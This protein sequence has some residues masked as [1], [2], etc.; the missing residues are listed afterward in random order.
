MRTI[1]HSEVVQAH[2]DD[3]W[4]VLFNRF[5]HVNDWNPNIEHSSNLTERD[6]EIG[7]E[8]MCQIDKDHFVREKITKREG[9]EAME[10]T[11][12]DGGPPLMDESKG[13]FE[14][15]PMGPE[16]TEVT[17]AITF[18]TKPRF[19]RHFLGL[20]V[21]R[22]LKNTLIGLKYHLET[23]G[24]V[25]KQNIRTIRRE[26]NNLGTDFLFSRVLDGDLSAA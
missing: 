6:G 13:R 15:R 21:K 24:L 4:N 19:A 1:Q 25:S 12:V 7:S 5:C 2:K 8:R 23:G 18:N 9:K 10:L 11:I 14:L 16:R 17:F 26:Y 20:G 3:V 22:L